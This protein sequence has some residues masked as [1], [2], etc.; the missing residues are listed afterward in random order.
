LGIDD[1]KR[2]ARENRIDIARLETALH[3][4]SRAAKKEHPLA[5]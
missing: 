5:A 1:L 3:R 2:F 4:Y